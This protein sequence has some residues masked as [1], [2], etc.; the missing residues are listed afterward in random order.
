MYHDLKFSEKE[1]AKVN[2]KAEDF[3]VQ[4]DKTK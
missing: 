3:N 4:E 2:M 1:Q